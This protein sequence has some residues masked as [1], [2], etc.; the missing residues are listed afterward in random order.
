MKRTLTLLLLLLSTLLLNISCKNSGTNNSASVIGGLV[1]MVV[2]LPKTGEK[3]LNVSIFA[4]TVVYIP[5][6]TTKESLVGHIDQI[7]MNDSLILIDDSDQGLLLFGQDGDFI[8]KIGKNGRGPEEYLSIFAFDVI[9]DTIYVS[10]TGRRGFLKYTFDG[11]FC[12]EVKLDYQPVYFGFTAD[13]RF[14]YYDHGEG[15][16][17]NYNNGFE[18]ADTMVVEYGVTEGRHSYI[19]MTDAYLNHLQKTSSGILFNSYLGDTIW[20]ITGTGKEPAFI[21]DTEEELLPY[22][23]Q[24]EFCNG[25]FDSFDRNARTYSLFHLLPVN[26]LLFVFQLHHTIYGSGYDAFYIC[27]PRTGET[28]RYDT[29]Y[30]FDDLVGRQKLTNEKM[31]GFF[32]VYSDEYLVNSISATNVIKRL[33]EIKENSEVAPSDSWMKQMGNIKENDNPVIVKIRVKDNS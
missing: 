2:H 19:Q 23:K 5:L 13:H 24:I 8:R 33:E 11:S 12:G 32:P 17:Y 4:D 9:R 26:S 29:S 10:S 30:M 16:V 3:T 14:V 18:R 28:R 1:P 21:L 22:E 15:L 20:N 7:W 27:E 25:D 31:S 6:E